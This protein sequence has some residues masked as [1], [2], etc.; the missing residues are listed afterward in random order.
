MKGFLNG[1]MRKDHAKEVDFYQRAIDAIQKGRKLWANVPD[2]DR[3]STFKESFL[4]A[5]QRCKLQA[6][7]SVREYSSCRT[8]A[9]ICFLLQAYDR[10]NGRD[11]RFSV[12]KMEEAAHELY[13][14]V[15]SARGKL[16]SMEIILIGPEQYLG[17]C[18]VYLL[19]VFPPH[20]SKFLS[21]L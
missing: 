15:E 20:L 16:S 12:D 19:G 7:V 5:V 6:F 11:H 17:A 4:F 1:G 8:K 21:V 13:A 9:S 2:D 10:A 18:P 14:D 3:G